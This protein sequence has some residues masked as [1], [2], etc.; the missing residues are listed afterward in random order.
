MKR[1]DKISSLGWF[2]EASLSFDRGNKNRCVYAAFIVCGRRVQGYGLRVVLAFKL[3]RG[4]GVPTCP[5]HYAWV[6]CGSTLAG[7]VT[8]GQFQQQIG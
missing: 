5:I 8:V 7:V 4:C 3:R 1:L 2:C 6:E